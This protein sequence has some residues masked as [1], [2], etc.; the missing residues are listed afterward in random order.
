MNLSLKGQTAVVT[1]GASG[2]GLAITRCFVESEAKVA[3]IGTRPYEQVKETLEEFGENTVYYSYDLKNTDH[4]QEL[5]DRIIRE[6]G[7]VS[8][9]VNNAGNHCKKYIWDMTVEDYKNVLDLQ[10]VGAFAITKAFVPQM[11]KAG[12]GRILFQ[13]SMTSMIGQPQVSGYA[14]AKAGYLGLV[15]TLTAELAPFGITVNAIAPGWIDTPMFRQATDGDS[16][17]MDKILGRIPAGKIGDPMDI[18]RCAVFLCSQA[19]A[20]INGACIPVDGGAL[21][22]F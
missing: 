1:G 4:I 11:K 17:R 16:K 9:L 3:V 2:L 5:A 10:L 22:G 18:G 8:I 12:Y 6:N 7:P 19:A 14:T 13:A 21:I 15:H 20:Y